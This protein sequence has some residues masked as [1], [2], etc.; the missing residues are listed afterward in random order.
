M[1]SGSDNDFK[2]LDSK[3][4]AIKEC[5]SAIK[6]NVNRGLIKK[7]E[8]FDSKSCSSDSD[9]SQELVRLSKAL[10]S[11][12]SNDQILQNSVTMDCIGPLVDR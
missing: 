3:C 2:F 11:K 6:P 4:V 9:D 7:Q 5:Q 1:S 8:Y 10:K 12:L